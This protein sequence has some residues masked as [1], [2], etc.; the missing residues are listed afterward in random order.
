MVRVVR[1]EEGEGGGG[2]REI[3]EIPPD[4]RKCCYRVLSFDVLRVY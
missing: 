2:R 1:V 3:G 4:G